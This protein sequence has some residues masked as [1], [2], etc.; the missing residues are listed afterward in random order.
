[1]LEAEVAASSATSSQAPPQPPK[2]YLCPISHQIMIN[3]VLLVEKGDSYE[4]AN[5][6]GWLHTYST[7]PLTGQ[8]LQIKQ[9]SSNRALKNLT[10]DWAAAHGIVLPAA[11]T[12][13]PVLSS[14]TSP[15][16]ASAAAAASSSMPHTVLSLPHLGGG[17][18]GSASKR[19][20]FRCSRTRWAITALAL[21]V[22]LGVAV[23]VGVGVATRQLQTIGRTP[24]SKPSV[25]SYKGSLLFPARPQPQD[26]GGQPQTCRQQ[27]ATFACTCHRMKHLAS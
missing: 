16:T 6:T 15:A 4:A 11:P 25:S 14:S 5:I 12:Y 7:C 2:E 20:I 3:P 17:R 19:N 18:S 10:A 24:G 23:G 8:H 13:T 21:L 26:E 9:L 22:V 1:V 27:S